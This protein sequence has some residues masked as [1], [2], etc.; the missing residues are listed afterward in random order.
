MA[1]NQL[2]V[3]EDYCNAMGDFFNRQGENLESMILEYVS[4]LKTIRNAAVIDG[5]V[6]QALEE[7]IT[8][9]EK[10]KNQIGPVSSVA[11]TSVTKYL[12]EIDEKDQY[13]F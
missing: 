2:I 12:Q 4:E 11:K 8:Y 6:S 13:L 9:S 10:L 5:A 7:F 1:A 3:D